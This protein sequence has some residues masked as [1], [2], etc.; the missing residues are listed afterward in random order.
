MILKSISGMCVCNTTR[1]PTVAFHQG[2]NDKLLKRF[3]W[4][5]PD[6]TL[7]VFDKG[8]LTRHVLTKKKIKNNNHLFAFFF[9]R[10]N[11]RDNT[12]ITS[13]F[14]NFNF[15]KIRTFFICNSSLVNIPWRISECPPCVMHKSKFLFKYHTLCI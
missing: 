3:G 9:R 1:E 15:T 13:F 11:R 2:R 4:K 7:I 8:L 5:S 6:K 10:Y 14:S 12:T